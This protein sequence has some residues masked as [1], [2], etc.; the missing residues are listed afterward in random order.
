MQGPAFQPWELRGLLGLCVILKKMGV[1]VR[2]S[3]PLDTEQVMLE[4]HEVFDTGWEFD[5]GRRGCGYYHERSP[6][7]FWD[8][9]QRLHCHGQRPQCVRVLACL[10]PYHF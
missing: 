2:F 8:S 5:L 9:V 6:I 3:S 10:Y 7:D 4:L 1:L